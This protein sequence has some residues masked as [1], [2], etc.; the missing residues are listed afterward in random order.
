MQ[1]KEG[2]YYFIYC[3]ILSI[4]TYKLIVTGKLQCTQTLN[5]YLCKFEQQPSN[6]LLDYIAFRS[7]RNDAIPNRA[8]Y[9]KTLLM[10]YKR[11]SYIMKSLLLASI[12]AGPLFTSVV[13]LFTLQATWNIMILLLNYIVKLFRYCLD[14][15]C[16][17]CKAKPDV[18]T[19]YY[20]FFGY[21]VNIQVY[22]GMQAKRLSICL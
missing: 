20:I 10:H 5:R 1:F 13:K 16:G 12:H 11:Q 21:F 18:V 15:R 8:V 7:H 22:N 14:D 6:P 19:A 9:R 17:N 4:Y 3:V 2:T